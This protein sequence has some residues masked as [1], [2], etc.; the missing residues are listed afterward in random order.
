MVGLTGQAHTAVTSASKF[1][2]LRSR[3]GALPRSWRVAHV[4]LRMA[5]TALAQWRT[6]RP[7][8]TVRRQLI[9][10]TIPLF[11]EV[12]PEGGVLN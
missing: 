10:R 9:R 5:Y 6:P 4:F 1:E 3:C 7:R 11:Y 2:G 8:W 12:E